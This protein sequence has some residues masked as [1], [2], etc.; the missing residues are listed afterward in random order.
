MVEE[1]KV[2]PLNP[3]KVPDEEHLGDAG[4]KLPG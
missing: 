3:P 2:M 1:V 4:A